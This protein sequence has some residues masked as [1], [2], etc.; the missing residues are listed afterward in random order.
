MGCRTIDFGG[1]HVCLGREGWSPLTAL[2]NISVQSEAPLCISFCNKKMIFVLSVY[3]KKNNKFTWAAKSSCLFLFLVW[4]W[5]HECIDTGHLE[6]IQYILHNILVHFH[7][8]KGMIY[9]NHSSMTSKN[10]K[11]M[12]KSS[13]LIWLQKHVV[14]CVFEETNLGTILQQSHSHVRNR[15]KKS[16]QINKN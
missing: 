11:V 15:E 4:L 9:C 1:M 10:T 12:V 14:E 3:F 8:K 5:W 7:R 16:V 2:N 13:Q 6:C